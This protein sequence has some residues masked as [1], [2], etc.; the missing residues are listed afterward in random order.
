ML[1]GTRIERLRIKAQGR[2]GVPLVQ[3]TV[4]DAFR[5]QLSAAGP[6]VQRG[7]LVIRK[8]DLGPIAS[9]TDQATVN[10]R[11][12]AMLR[13][14]VRQAGRFDP[15][16]ADTGDAVL[17]PDP[18]FPFLHLA[19][20]ISSGRTI[21]QSWPWRAVLG[22]TLFAS[23]EELAAELVMRQLETAQAGPA[24]RAILRAFGPALLEVASSWS[25]PMRAHV[26]A[27]VCVDTAHVGKRPVTVHDLSKLSQDLWS[28]TGSAPFQFLWRR[29]HREVA[30]GSQI[31]PLAVALH[32]GPDS[33]PVAARR[34][35]LTA[36]L[37][38]QLVNGRVWGKAQ[39]LQLRDLA[40]LV[41]VQST[42][43]R[44]LPAGFSLEMTTAQLA[45]VLATAFI[46][47][48][49]KQ[50]SNAVTLPKVA[51]CT[52]SETQEIEPPPS[53]LEV[54]EAPLADFRHS[55]F[56]PTRHAGMAYLITLI[57]RSYG[58]WLNR[59]EHL[60]AGT[61]QRLLTQVIGRFALHPE[62]PVQCFLHALGD[63]HQGEEVP[64]EFYLADEMLGEASRP[65]RVA[66][67]AGNRGWRMA[68]SGRVVVAC[69]QG[70]APREIRRLLKG[71][72]RVERA[73]AAPWSSVA[74]LASC[75]IGLRRYLRNGPKLRMAQLVRRHGELAHTATHLDISF[76]ALV[77]DLAVRRW[78]LDLS[79]GWCP[80]LWRV[81]TIHYDFG[82]TDAG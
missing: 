78:A 70:P 1:E 14:A 19:R 35:A 59:G 29:L 42:A 80:W 6:A 30:L 39:R 31:L 57:Q 26:V 58:R 60:L 7:L 10:R 13:D 33:R 34:A 53:E 68:S 72:P 81:V 21:P 75:E 32:L 2:R 62:D 50:A 67:I 38:E 65:I 25:S 56:E 52:T 74:M 20:C 18:L 44:K 11:L 40:E 8:I 49:G 41:E 24:V 23:R 46:S 27:A 15:A 37:L 64:M 61:G 45:K 4:E 82:E 66:P 73:S 3:S 43:L 55:A 69:W 71:R 63:K 9:R 12:A 5:T 22:D 17:F 28:L 36:G 54:G 79:P 16:R 47:A 48:E 51:R 77:I 76:D